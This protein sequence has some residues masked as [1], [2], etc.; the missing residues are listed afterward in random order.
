MPYNELVRDPSAI[1]GT[2]I[3]Y[4]AQVFQYDTNTGLKSMLVYVDNLGGGVWDGLVWVK[5][6]SS[7]IAHDVYQQDIVRFWGAVSGSYTY[8]TQ[9]GGTDTVPTVSVRYISL[10]SSAGG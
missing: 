10:V 7:A 4:E 3:T 8:T 6:P 2:R 1:A 5:L 9:A